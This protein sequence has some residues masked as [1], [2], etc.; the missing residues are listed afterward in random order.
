MLAAGGMLTTVC[1]FSLTGYA[2]AVIAEEAVELLTADETGAEVAAEVEM[3]AAEE[4]PEEIRTDEDAS[5]DA[6]AESKTEE[7]SETGGDVPEIPTG[8]DDFLESVVEVE[9]ALTEEKEYAAGGSDIESA[10]KITSV[11]GNYTAEISIACSKAYFSFTPDETCGYKFYSTSDFDT[12]VQLLD[13][14]SN[15]I[16]SDDDSGEDENFLICSELKKDELYYFV[17]SYYSDYETGS[18]PVRIE[19]SSFA[20]LKTGI[21]KT[22]QMGSSLTLDPSEYFRYYGSDTTT[23]TYQWSNGEIDI[24]KEPTLV[25]NNGGD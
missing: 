1:P 3:E 25:I 16:T 17:V 20:V 19:K 9:E 15:I 2:E 12:E 18:I 5:E 7:G 23:L 6:E 24:S 21:E 11:P 10:E 8:E 22:M 14:E 13:S 4:A